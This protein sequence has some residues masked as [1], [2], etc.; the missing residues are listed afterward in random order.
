MFNLSVFDP[1]TLFSDLGMIMALLLVGKLIRAKVC[2][3]QKLFIPPSMIAGVLG[4]TFGPNG[5]GWLPL[6]GSVSVYPAIL[7]AVVFGALPLSSP[8]FK[9]KEVAG[10]VGPMWVYSQFGMLFQWSVMGL[11]GI[12]VMKALWPELNDAFGVM[13]PTGFY[14]GH[15]TAAAI[16]SAF[17]GLGWDEA[18]SL[19]MTTATIGVILAVLGGLLFIKMAA[20][21]GDTSYISDFCDLPS[22][23]RSGLLPEDRREPSGQMTTSPISID[24]LT[25]HFALVVVA[26]FGGYLISKGVKML[27]PQLELPVFSCAFVVGLILKTIFNRTGISR[28][29]DPKTTSSISSFATDLLVAFGIASIKLSVVVKYAVPLAVLLVVGIALTIF[30]VFY[31]GR[32]LLKKDWF[33]K[34]IFAWGWWTGT[35]AMG[36]ALLRIVDPKMASKAMDDYALAY[37]PCAP[38]EILL[39]TFVPVMFAAGN[40]LWMML[41]CLAIS[42]LLLLFAGLMKWWIPGGRRDGRPS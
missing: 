5:L 37:L 11:F 41:L 15:G 26:A 17:D 18:G 22:E 9:V 6:S 10:R 29:I 30:T 1:W 2:W 33:E 20:R 14:G 36:I 3:I 34:S 21:R 13:L 7:I 40:G 8:A 24:S 31:F 12:I 38:V 23:L 35:M 42:L 16:G 4:L 25:F 28:Y 39:I 32:R 27:N 19:G